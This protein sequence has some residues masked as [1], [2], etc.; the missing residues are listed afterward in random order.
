VQLGYVLWREIAGVVFVAVYFC[1][2]PPLL[3]R[4]ILRGLRRRMTLGRY[5]LLALLLLLMLTL[6]LK[7]I[8]RWTMNLSYIVSMPEYYLNF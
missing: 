2:L 3:G 6:P 8:L 5:T 4:T 1:A 7:M